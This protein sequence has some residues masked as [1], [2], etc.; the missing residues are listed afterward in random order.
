MLLRPTDDELLGIV[1]QI[2]LME[3]RGVHGVEELV[4]LLELDLD[5][6]GHG[7]RFGEWNDETKIRN[8]E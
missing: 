8:D 1:I 2:P 3:G 6:T 7:G 4:Q 5:E